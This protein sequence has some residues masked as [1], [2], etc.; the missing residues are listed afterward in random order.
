MTGET[1]TVLRALPPFSAGW[2]GAAL[3][4]L[5][6]L[7]W[8]FYRTERAGERGTFGA[9]LRTLIYCGLAATWGGWSL[10]TRHIKLSEFV[11]AVDESRSQRGAFQES[12]PGAATAA[13]E[14]NRAAVET[15]SQRYRTRT[16]AVGADGRSALGDDLIRIAE[17]QRGR[18]TAGVLLISDGRV[19]AGRSLDAAVEELRRRHIPLYVAGSAAAAPPPDV[20]I[21]EVEV[22]DQAFVRDQLAFE[23]RLHAQAIDTPITVRLTDAD[24]A[25]LAETIAM[26]ADD[27]ARATLLYRPTTAGDH[28][29]RIDAATAVVEADTTNNAAERT[30]NVA[31]ADFQVLLVAGRPSYEFRRLKT[32]LE[33]EFSAGEAESRKPT[34]KTVLQDADP[35]YAELDRTALAN[36]P[37]TRE[38]LFAFDVLL[39]IDPQPQPIGVAGWTLLREFVLEKGGGLAIVAG[40]Q[41]DVDLWRVLPKELLP[42]EISTASVAKDDAA[43]YRFA[44]T[45]LGRAARP[46]AL[47]DTSAEND[48]VWDRLPPFL[49]RVAVPQ[50]H[51]GVRVLAEFHALHQ[52]PSPSL[53]LHFSGAGRVLFQASDESYR[54]AYRAGDVHFGR[55]WQQWIRYLARGKLRSDAAQ[56]SVDREQVPFGEA[57]RLRVR[58]G[59]SARA[60]EAVRL[61]LARDD[62]YT[63]SLTA[64]AASL[65]RGE[66]ETTVSDLPPGRYIARLE[67]PADV[68]AEAIVT[69]TEPAA[70]APG[71]VADETVLRRTAEVTGGKYR[72]ATDLAPLLAEIPPPTK[73]PTGP[74]TDRP[75][76]NSPLVAAALIGLLC[77]EWVWRRRRG[78]Y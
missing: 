55:Y 39:L 60:P 6:A 74:A 70:E 29:Y 34:L 33:R 38:Q 69:V 64:H 11:I 31:P 78:M 2:V 56:V 12:S 27:T 58:L 22:D 61:R 14:A 76:W 28:R 9:V 40:P 51:P 19:N 63:R 23:V 30:V 42:A 41:A 52:P 17:Q 21:V 16:V 3:L 57:V 36:F 37:L 7:A 8:W 59:E 48:L 45:P 35:E 72:S 75:L 4:V 32:T 68:P 54:L 25:T 18:S 67:T 44:L 50:V 53:T 43:E 46:L 62:G 24:G 20:A 73:S 5:I 71:A 13:L 15:F 10:R 47:A 49:F 1:A 77:G 65:E 26:I 66:F